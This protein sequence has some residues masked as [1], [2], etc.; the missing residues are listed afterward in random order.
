[1][2]MN[3]NQVLVKPV[4]TEKATIISEQNK[5]VFEV[6]QRANKDQISQAIKAIYNVVPLKVN[7][8][9]VRG[10]ERRL[11]LG[12]G[13]TS[14]WKKAIVTLKDGDKIDLFETK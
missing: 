11:R 1:M 9:N 7:I 5:Y 13:Y 8:V 2:T 10:K 4:I 14:A 3:V 12:T 6:A